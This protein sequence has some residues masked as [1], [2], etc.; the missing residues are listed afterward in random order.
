MLKSKLS[1]S[2]QAGFDFPF[3]SFFLLARLETSMKS[4][5][6]TSGCPDGEGVRHIKTWAS[7]L[8]LD[9]FPRFA[10]KEK[11]RILANRK[12]NSTV[13]FKK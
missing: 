5:N 9:F 8:C 13:C 10:L 4:N 12:S 6:N 7:F 3:I 11:P 2:L 1:T